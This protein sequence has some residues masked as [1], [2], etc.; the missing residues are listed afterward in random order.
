MAKK[1]QFVVPRHSKGLLAERALSPPQIGPLVLGAYLKERDPSLDVS[2]YDENTS[3]DR[4][5]P[6]LLDGD[7]VGISTW[8]SN[9]DSALEIAKKVK[10]KRGEKTRV[11]LGGPNVTGIEKRILENNPE[12]DMVISGEGENPIGMLVNG[13]EL[14]TIPGLTYRQGSEIKTNPQAQGKLLSEIPNFDLS[15]LKTH[16]EWPKGDVPTMSAFPLSGLRGCF[17]KKRCDWCSINTCGVRTSSAEKYWDQIRTLREK[18]GIN[19]FFESGDT[20]T[21]EFVHELAISRPEDLPQD[22]R[23]R[24]YSHI[25]FVTEG[26]L[27]DLKKTGFDN[28]FFGIESNVVQGTKYSAQR[29]RQD[30]DLVKKSGLKILPAMILGL[31]GQDEDSLRK[32]LS[33]IEELLSDESFAPI[34]LLNTPY[35]FQGS[36][37]FNWCL[38]NKTIVNQ[39]QERTG[40]DLLKT[41]RINIPVLSELFVNAHTPLGYNRIQKEV[42]RFVETHKDRV[43]YWVTPS[44]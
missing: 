32:D 42:S 33:F 23:I 36:N 38:D 16:Y 31:P 27:T 12:I 26:Y 17:R 40:E 8:F 15:M 39:Y 25:G 5:S 44:K 6:D 41:D 21:P 35:P 9:Y 2:V 34:C 11:I 7:F 24:G 28:L 43:A 30:L 3:E 37:Y 13:N 20:L 18:N 14:S 29:M 19:Y 10:N 1:I 22:V 4:A